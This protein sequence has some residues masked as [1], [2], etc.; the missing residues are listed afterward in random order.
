MQVDFA[1]GERK[2]SPAFR[3]K[4]SAVVKS[5]LAEATDTDGARAFNVTI[6]HG[7]VELRVVDSY[8]HLGSYLCCDSSLVAARRRF[9]SAL[10]EFAP[11]AP[12]IFGSSSIS[13]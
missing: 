12:K 1:K 4:D 5:Q 9:K 8:K 2:V 10:S 11:I 13:L 3:D 7:P 6:A